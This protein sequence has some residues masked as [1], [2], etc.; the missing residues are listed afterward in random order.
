MALTRPQTFSE[1]IDFTFTRYREVLTFG[2]IMGTIAQLVATLNLLGHPEQ[3]ERMM[4]MM[5]LP[6]PMTPHNFV[7]MTLPFLPLAA[8]FVLVL[9]AWLAHLM[10][11]IVLKTEAGFGPMLKVIAYAEAASLLFLVPIIGPYAYKFLFLF[12]VLMGIRTAYGATTGQA[13]LV[14]LPTLFL[15]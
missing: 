2:I 7:F 11:R 3:F 9:K 12:L 5:G 8:A 10:A 13:V 4:E 1:R 15:S 14:L 6:E